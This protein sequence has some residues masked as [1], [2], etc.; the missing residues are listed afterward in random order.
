M[1]VLWETA[2]AVLEAVRDAA[3]PAEQVLQRAGDAP[4]SWLP[5]G[6]AAAR[7]PCFQLWTEGDTPPLTLYGGRDLSLLVVADRAALGLSLSE[8][9]LALW[10]LLD[11]GPRRLPALDA[12]RLAPGPMS[13]FIGRRQ[14][15]GHG[16]PPEQASGWQQLLDQAVRHWTVR[17]SRTRTEQEWRRNLEV[18]DGEDWTARVRRLADGLIE[19]TPTRSSELLRDLI[20]FVRAAAPERLAG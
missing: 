8:I 11:L 5:Q 4:P 9:P 14:A 1:R 17:A 3:V 15:H 2:P 16:L 20:G 13:T 12:V 6:I 19:L 18:L 10:G 7:T